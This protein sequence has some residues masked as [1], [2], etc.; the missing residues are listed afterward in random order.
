MLSS[1]G[2]TWVP[3]SQIHI[4]PFEPEVQIKSQWTLLQTL[5]PKINI[6]Y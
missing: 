2:S 5:D 6:L 3:S 4:G 1:T